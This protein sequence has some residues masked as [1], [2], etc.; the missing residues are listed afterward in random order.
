MLHCFPEALVA[1][2]RGSVQ[3]EHPSS[4]MLGPEVLQIWDSFC[5]LGDICINMDHFRMRPNSKHK[6]HLFHKVLI[7]LAEGNFTY[8]IFSATSV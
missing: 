8:T 1:N 2:G 4:K 7:Y 3:V 5:R 6:I